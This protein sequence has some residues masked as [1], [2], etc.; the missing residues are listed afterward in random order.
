MLAVQHM[1]LSRDEREAIAY[2]A[3][4]HEFALKKVDTSTMLWA[5]QVRDQ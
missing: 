1:E 4:E 5:S 2:H 3:I